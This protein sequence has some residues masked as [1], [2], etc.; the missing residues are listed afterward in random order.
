MTTDGIDQNVS[1][2]DFLFNQNANNEHIIK[3]K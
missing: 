1:E 3:N 2:K